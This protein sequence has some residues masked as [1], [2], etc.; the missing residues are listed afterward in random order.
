MLRPVG[1]VLVSGASLAAFV[2]AGAATPDPVGLADVSGWLERVDPVD[3]LVEVARIAGIVLAAYV[4]LVSV[5]ALVAEVAGLAKLARVQRLLSRIAGAIA[6]PSLRRRLLELGTAASIS[7]ATIPSMAMAAPPSAPVVQVAEV[8]APQD[9]VL[10]AEFRGFDLPVEHSTP[11]ATI[12]VVEQGDTLWSI[13]TAHYGRFDQ[14]LLDAVVDANPSVEDPNLIL[15]GW[16]ITLPASPDAAAQGPVEQAPVPT[17]ESSWTAVT[18]QRGDTLWEIVDRHYGNATGELIWAVVDANSEIDNPDLIYAGQVIT[19]PPLGGAE[20]VQ[21]SEPSAPSA[22]GEEP[23]PPAFDPPTSDPSDSSPPTPTSANKVPSS[24]PELKEA[25]PANS[26]PSTTVVESSSPS[27]PAATSTA[28]D[29]S[30]SDDV[31]NDVEPGDEVPGP[32]VAQLVGWSGGA[33]LAAAILGLAARRRRRQPPRERT[34]RPSRRAAQLGVALRLT[35]NLT[36]VEWASLALREMAARLRPAPGRTN[37][38]P[39]LLRLAGEEIELMWDS[40]SPD[41]LEPWTSPDG[42]WSWTRSRP[43]DFDV[44]GT[45]HPCPAL[46]TIGRR[47][48]ADVLLNIECC[49]ALALV[50]DCDVIDDFVRHLCLELGASPFADAPTLLVVSD[51]GSIPGEPE[52]VRMAAVDEAEAWLRDRSDASS[53]LLSS[54]RLTS[55]FTMRA[56]AKPQDSHEPVVVVV[57]AASVGA[58]AIARLIAVTNGDLGAIVVV[59]GDDPSVSWRLR[60]ADSTVTL[61]PLGLELERIGL[62]EQTADLVEEIVPPGDSSIDEDPVPTFDLADAE[63]PTLLLPQ[64]TEDLTVELEDEDEDFDVELKVLGQVRAVGTK[65]PL[66]PTELHLAIYLAFHR[67]GENADTISTM[68]W[69]DG[70]RPKT[71]VNTMASLRRKLGTGSDGQMLFPLGRDNQYTYRLSDRVVTDWDRF[72]ALARRAE[73]AEPDDAIALLERAIAL[74]DGPPFRASAGYSWAYSEGISTSIVEQAVRVGEAALRCCLERGG[75][76]DAA[77]LGAFILSSVDS[78][79]DAQLIVQLTAEA[80]HLLGNQTEAQRLRNSLVSALD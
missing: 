66:T 22:G 71:L 50:G 73:T 1:F 55:L 33:A 52:H 41:L 6:L 39:R 24:E 68:I 35:D 27:V 63:A 53:A 30:V 56:R 49:G 36:T 46:V 65:Q 16:R 12:H 21:S 75:L 70:A 26:M 60:F 61:E 58:E 11:E 14:A 23:A 18:V 28:T 4:L 54:R 67:N 44:R 48:G 62:S 20:V 74:I 19:L 77:R 9:V 57:D 3:A 15:A 43:D 29:D 78:P 7:A 10:G 45:P 13:I 17:G 51:S 31:L 76:D 8:A 79:L 38:V 25:E 80:H 69:P 5:L 34:V 2:V 37:P 32:S 40:P 64:L 47:G 42:G 72:V 59:H